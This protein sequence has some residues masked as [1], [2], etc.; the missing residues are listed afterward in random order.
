MSNSSWISPTISS[1]M[2]STVSIPAV[3]PYSSMTRAMWALA[4]C[5]WRR[6]WLISRLAGTAMSGRVMRVR[7]LCLAA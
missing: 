1:R 6:T 3:P 5:I 4:F 7:S 2:S